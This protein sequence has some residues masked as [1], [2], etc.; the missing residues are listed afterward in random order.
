MSTGLAVSGTQAGLS[1]VLCTKRC[2]RERMDYN[3]SC[4]LIALGRET[5]ES[6]MG[7]YVRTI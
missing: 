3:F 5:E 2:G 6:P 4:N 1:A 7:E